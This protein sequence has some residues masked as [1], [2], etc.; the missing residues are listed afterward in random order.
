MLI[1]VTC[2][3]LLSG[4]VNKTPDS[5]VYEFWLQTGE[6]FREPIIYMFSNI[7]NITNYS[8]FHKIMIVLISVNIYFFLKK[9][10]KEFSY[11]VFPFFFYYFIE[12]LHLTSQLRF[13]LAFFLFLNGYFNGNAKR[14]FLF[15]TLSLVCHF[16]VLF[17]ILGSLV[18]SKRYKEGVNYLSFL[19]LPIFLYVIFTPH[20]FDLATNLLDMYFV[21]YMRYLETNNGRYSSFIGGAVTLFPYVLLNLYTLIYGKTLLHSEFSHRHRNLIKFQFYILPI[22]IFVKIFGDRFIKPLLIISL[23]YAFHIASK[24]TDRNYHYVVILSILMLI[25]LNT[26]ILEYVMS[27]EFL[28][29][30]A[31]FQLMRSII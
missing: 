10:K 2:F 26:Y 17:L 11:I 24:K 12:Y 1:I 22:C 20:I 31:S 23:S 4:F 16:S 15:Y 8:E 25:L 9:L 6:G 21:D 14:E 7:L 28:R 3:L 18:V 27:N 19:S 30:R 13:Y 29:I 5:D